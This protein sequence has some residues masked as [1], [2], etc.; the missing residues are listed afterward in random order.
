MIAAQGKC[1]NK[2]EMHTKTLVIRIAS[3]K[4]L[5]NNYSSNRSEA[6]AERRGRY[7]NGSDIAK[8]RQN[9]NN[10]EMEIEKLCTTKTSFLMAYTENARFILHLLVLLYEKY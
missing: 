9:A 10:S 7:C 5:E 2:V 1:S 8:S 6:V 3:N 4:M